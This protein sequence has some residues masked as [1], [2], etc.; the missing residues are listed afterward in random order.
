MHDTNT[1]TIACDDKRNF[2]V[3]VSQITCQIELTAYRGPNY[4]VGLLD[5]PTTLSTAV[6]VHSSIT[7]M[8]SLMRFV[9]AKPTLS[10]PLP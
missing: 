3:A 6:T 8:H 2:A 5:R 9:D 7:F 1:C 10:W 4:I